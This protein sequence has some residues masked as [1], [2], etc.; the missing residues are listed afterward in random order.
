MFNDMEKYAKRVSLSSLSHVTNPSIRPRSSF[1]KRKTKFE[2]VPLIVF[3]FSS[4]K[5]LRLLTG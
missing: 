4:D 5:C 2:E 1:G 3:L